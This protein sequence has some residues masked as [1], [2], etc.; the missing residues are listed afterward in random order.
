MIELLIARLVRQ[1]DRLAVIAS[2]KR[3]RPLR[4]SRPKC[5]RPGQTER[6]HKPILPHKPHHP[7]SSLSLIPYTPS[8]PA[9]I[10]M[11][12]TPR[13]LLLKHYEVRSG[14][15]ASIVASDSIGLATP[16]KVLALHLVL[17]HRS[18]RPCAPGN[19]QLVQT[20]LAQLL[21]RLQLHESRLRW[22]DACSVLARA[23]LAESSSVARVASAQSPLLVR[24]LFAICAN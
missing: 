4:H 15:G 21:Q 13:I 7:L 24:A 18:Y 9:N 20:Q 16:T 17:D 8:I 23:R 12:T 1:T 10:A 22:R 14:S 6:S 19:V 3:K 11:S 5:F 2:S